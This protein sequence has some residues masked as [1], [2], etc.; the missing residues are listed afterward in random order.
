MVDAGQQLDCKQDILAELPAR[1][2]SE[3]GPALLSGT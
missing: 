3:S 1:G 2:Q